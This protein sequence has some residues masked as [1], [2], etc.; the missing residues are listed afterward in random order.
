[1]KSLKNVLISIGLLLISGIGQTIAQD[2]IKVIKP[3]IGFEYRINSKVLNETR[4]YL[5]S[6]P[7]EY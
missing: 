1:M 5:V 2:K 4:R 3:D 7:A 6:L